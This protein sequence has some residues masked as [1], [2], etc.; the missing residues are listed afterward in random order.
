MPSIK[1]NIPVRTP[2]GVKDPIWGTEN[3]SM[4]ISNLGWKVTSFF[5]IYYAIISQISYEIFTYFILIFID[6]IISDIVGL[7]IGY[8]TIKLFFG[9]FQYEV[10]SFSLI[11]KELRKHNKLLVYVLT[12]LFQTIFFIAGTHNLLM[13][14]L[15]IPKFPA[16]LLTWLVLALI[17]KLLGRGLFFLFYKF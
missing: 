12:I 7:V 10:K 13:A 8:A 15:D 5:I 6:Y 2:R 1:K 11:L 4:F 16:L 14:W 17:A 3:I 9:I